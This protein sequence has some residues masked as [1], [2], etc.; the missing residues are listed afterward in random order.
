MAS[1]ID[2]TLAAANAQTTAIL[3]GPEKRLNVEVTESVAT[4]LMTVSIQ[5][6]LWSPGDNPGVPANDDS[7]WVTV[8]DITAIPTV[9]TSA[10]GGAFFRAK[11]TAWTSGTAGVK[12]TSATAT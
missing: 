2:T 9:W 7:R 4:Y 5:Q 3:V 11:A 1:G 10:H 12:L 6:I 8:R